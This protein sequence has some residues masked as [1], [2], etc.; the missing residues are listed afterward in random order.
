MSA[1]HRGDTKVSLFTG[2]IDH[3]FVMTVIIALLARLSSLEM[4]A[5]N[6]DLLFSVLDNIRTEEWLV[7][8]F[9]TNSEEFG[10]YVHIILQ[11]V[12]SS[13]LA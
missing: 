12:P 7:P 6:T 8:Q 11:T 4:L 2:L 10:T 1:L 9:L 5:N 3:L 13:K